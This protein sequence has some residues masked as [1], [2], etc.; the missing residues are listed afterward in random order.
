MM[1]L[2]VAAI[3]IGR[4]DDMRPLGVALTIL[5]LAATLIKVA[6]LM[7]HYLDLRR[8][9]AWNRALR[10]GAAV[11]LIVIAALSLIARHA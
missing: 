6:I 8:A 10:Y 9:P 11:V 1:A 3:P 5:L 4:A 7:N 2:S